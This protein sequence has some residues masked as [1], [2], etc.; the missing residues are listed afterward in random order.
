MIKEHGA[1][2]KNEHIR[3]FT[4]V[5][6]SLKTKHHVHLEDTK[7]LAKEEHFFKRRIREAI[8]I[9]K[10]PRNLN[11]DNGLDLSENWLPLIHNNK[12]KNR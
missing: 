4:L 11:K 6:H 9:C 3:S 7:F 10:H 5:E 2:I 12:R 8:E 1:D